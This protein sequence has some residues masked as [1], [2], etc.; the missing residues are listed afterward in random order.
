MDKK[1]FVVVFAAIIIAVTVSLFV[2]ATVSDI[3]TLGIGSTGRPIQCNDLTDNDGDGFTDYPEDPGCMNYKDDEFNSF[4]ECDDGKDNDGDGAVDMKDYG[5]V[6]PID[7][8]ETNCGDN[9]CEDFED[10][11]NCPEDCKMCL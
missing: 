3:M 4:V 2:S 8:D 11:E 7:V 5:C 6:S 10:C 1:F 9:E